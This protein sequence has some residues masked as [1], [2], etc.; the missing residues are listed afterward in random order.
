MDCF[1]ISMKYFLVALIIILSA[2]MLP[3]QV[4]NYSQEKLKLYEDSLHKLTDT[5]LDGSTQYARQTSSYAFIK[6]LVRA[7]KMPDSFIYPF[8]SL[9]RISI[10]TAPDKSFRIF[11]WE[12]L[13]DGNDGY[14]YYGAIQMNNKKLELFPLYDY[15]THISNIEDTV[16]D[17]NKWFGV[18]YYNLVEKKYFGKKYYTLFG[19]YGNNNSSTKKVIDILSFKN[20]KPVFGAPVFEIKT[21]NKNQIIDRFIIEY[22]KDATVHVNYDKDYKKIIYDHLIPETPGSEGVYSTYVPDG[23]YEGFKFRRGK[24]R[25]IENVFT[26]KG[27]R[28]SFPK[29]LDFNKIK[30]D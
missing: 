4:N 9:K 6:I 3:A 5:I 16:T 11:S 19:W 25:Y 27:K 8:D 30:M 20:N 7:L 18:L 29:P 1:C 10:L 15:S 12:L 26:S 13:L 23:T 2:E 14:H 24:W 28:V 22:K 21:K 17:N